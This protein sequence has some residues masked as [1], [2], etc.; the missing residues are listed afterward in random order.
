MCSIKF[1]FCMNLLSSIENHVD[2]SYVD[3]SHK[4][5]VLLDV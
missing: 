5:G 2:S 1:G 3:N 4:V